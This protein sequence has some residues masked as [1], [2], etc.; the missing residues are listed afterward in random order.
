MKRKRDDQFHA[1]IN[2]IGT[3]VLSLCAIIGVGLGVYRTARGLETAPRNL[4]GWAGPAVAHEAYEHLKGE[5][6]PFKIWGAEGQDNSR[7]RVCLWD[8]D[9]IVNGGKHLPTFRQEIGDCVQAGAMQA[10]HRLMTSQIVLGGSGEEFKPIFGPYHYACGRNA[11]ECGNG[12]MGR[13][14]SGST[15]AWQAVA[16]KLYGVLAQAPDLP[17][18]SARVVTEWATKMPARQYIERGQSHKVGSIALMRSAD[19]VRDAN[20]NG[21]PVTI[22][23]DAGFQMKPS[24]KDGRLVNRRVTRWNH[25]MCIIAYDGSGATEYYYVLNSWGP[26]A[27]GVPPDDA[28]PGGFWI[29]REDVE[30]IVRQGDSYALSQFDGFP[31]QDWP[32]VVGRQDHREANEVEIPLRKWHEDLARFERQE[33]ITNPFAHRQGPALRIMGP[34]AGEPLAPLGFVHA[35]ANPEAN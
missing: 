11:P 26:D 22:A 19:D 17:E 24:V 29:T 32:L 34:P 2:T 4:M 23:S 20:C 18:Y 27:H 6:V 7:K 15:G 33:R 14:P 13:D 9:K 21:Y 16:L 3:I 10:M 8:A 35:L 30:Y 25:Q 1:K 28:P 5:M 31:A 12:R